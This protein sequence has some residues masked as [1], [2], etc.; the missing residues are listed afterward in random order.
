MKG[1]DNANILMFESRDI[2]LNLATEEYIYEHL[3]ITNP[4]MVLWRN[5]KTVIIGK[6]QNPWQECKIDN[7]K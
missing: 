6:H 3:E 4:T 2:L 5:N 1:K 7:M